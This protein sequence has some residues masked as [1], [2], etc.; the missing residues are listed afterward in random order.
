VESSLAGGFAIGSH[1]LNILWVGA[2]GVVAVWLMRLSFE[3]VFFLTLRQAE[4]EREE[5]EPAP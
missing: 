4:S 2:S 5:R 1:L 3:D